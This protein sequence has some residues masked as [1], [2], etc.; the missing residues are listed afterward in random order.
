VTVATTAPE[1]LGLSRRH[2]AYLDAHVQRYID[3]GK[4]AGGLTLVARE[5][6]VA[7]F[8]P[9][10]LADKDRGAPLTHD[11]IFR[12]YSMTK[13]LTSIALMQLYERGL[14]QLDDPVHKYIPAWKDLAVYVSGEYPD[15]VTTRPER[16]M[17]IRDLLSH[18]SG[19]TYGFQDAGT[20]VDSAYQK[21]GVLSPRSTLDDMV[22]KLATLPLLFSPGTH[23]NY[24]VSTDVCGYLVQL[25]S[26]QRFDDYLAENVIEPL[27]MVDTGFFVPPEKAAPCAN[28]APTPAGGM[29]LIDDPQEASP[30][31]RAS[32]WRGRPRLHRERLPS[33]R[34]LTGERRHARRC[35]HHR[36]QDPRAMTRTIS[37]AAKTSPPSPSADAGLKPPSTGLASG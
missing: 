14:L 12:I 28:Y 13:P 7:H 2:L 11:T 5:G 37:Q 3:E 20:A 17:T 32:F 34:R 26:G 36:F 29:Q 1:S 30:P 6:E 24:S 19:L 27:G 25:L 23:W 15:F 22:Q 10:G 21:A 35:P 8:S 16:A 4:I 9:L 18:Q 31:S 33:L